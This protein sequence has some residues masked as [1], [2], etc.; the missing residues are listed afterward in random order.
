MSEIYFLLAIS[1]YLILAVLNKDYYHPGAMLVLLWL[2]SSALASYEPLYNSD[3]QSPISFEAHASILTAGMSLFLPAFIMSFYSKKINNDRL[4]SFY[5]SNKYALFLDFFICLSIFAFI[6]RFGAIIFQPPILYFGFSD[7]KESV[8]SG[9]PVIHY[10]DLLTPFLAIT[11]IH[12]LL[13]SEGMNRFRVWYFRLFIVF[14]LTTIIFYKISRGE[15]LIIILG[16][17]YLIYYKYRFSLAKMLSVVVC[18]IILFLLFTYLR[19]ST[20]GMVASYLGDGAASYI[21]PIYT[22]VAINFENFNK[23]TLSDEFNYTYYL[24]SLKFIIY[25]FYPELYNS[26]FGDIKDFNTL[27]FNA[28]PFIYYFY[29]DLGLF[30]VALYSSLISSLVSLFY[31]VSKRDVRYSL[32]L[33]FM[34]KAIFFLFFGNYFFGEMV[35]FFPYVFGMLAIIAMHKRVRVFS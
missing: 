1:I 12:A 18:I 13:F 22:Y 35:I 15:L 3:I 21:S 27:F 7:L 24:S 23:L 26:Q 31:L 29:H 11:V 25:P 6:I 10:F 16:W 9:I 20:G 33:S 28:K 19:L 2:L 32:M 8:P 17:L 30:G 5:F 14:S 4:E 34:Q